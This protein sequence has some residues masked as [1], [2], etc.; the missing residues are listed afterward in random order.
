LVETVLL[1]GIPHV[2]TMM[3]LLGGLGSSYAV[4]IAGEYCIVGEL[5]GV[6]TIGAAYVAVKAM[7]NVVG[8]NIEC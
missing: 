6:S 2:E 1:I 7:A 4:G 5:D 3:L 8:P